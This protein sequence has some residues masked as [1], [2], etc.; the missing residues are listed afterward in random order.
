L[1]RSEAEESGEIPRKK[2][3]QTKRVKE[4]HEKKKKRKKKKEKEKGKIKHDESRGT[5]RK[6]RS[7]LGEGEGKPVQLSQVPAMPTRSDVTLS[8]GMLHHIS[9][10]T[11]KSTMACLTCNCMVNL[12]E[13]F[14][15]AVGTMH[16]KF[17]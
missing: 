12:L 13:D 15:G 1:F 8:N 3:K 7:Q 2:E 14:G 9:C 5:K 6:H 10:P 16:F 4:K 17:A 11:W